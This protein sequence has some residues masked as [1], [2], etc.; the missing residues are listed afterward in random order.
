[1][2]DPDQS[3]RT[4]AISALTAKARLAR[5]VNQLPVNEA[6]RIATGQKIGYFQEWI[7]HKRYDG[8]WAAMDYRA[9]ASNLP[10]VVHLARGWWDFFL[11]NVLSDY[12]ALRDTGRCVRLFISSAAHGRNM[13]L[14]AYQRDAFATP[15]HAL[16]NRNLP[17]TDLPVRVTGTR[18]W[19]DLPGWPPAAALP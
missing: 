9:N 10:P 5:A 18:I 1:M 11:S 4:Q 13:A 3:L 19:T 15:D 14:R 16:M 12:V 17:G 6:D 2:L 8:Y 7:R